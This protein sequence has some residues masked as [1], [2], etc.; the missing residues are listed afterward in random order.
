MELKTLSEK[1]FIHQ[2]RSLQWGML[3]ALMWCAGLKEFAPESVTFGHY[4]AG[5]FGSMAYAILIA[6]SDPPELQYKA[7]KTI[8]A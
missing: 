3:G 5:A 2:Y 8:S 4:I 6:V 7:V 1:R